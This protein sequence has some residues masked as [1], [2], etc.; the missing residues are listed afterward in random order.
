MASQGL[1][2]SQEL[3]MKFCQH[4]NSKLNESNQEAINEQIKLQGYLH[5]GGSTSNFT[6]FLESRG[7][8]P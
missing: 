3:R 6:K 2:K 5:I 4:R 1:L 7:Q 8:E